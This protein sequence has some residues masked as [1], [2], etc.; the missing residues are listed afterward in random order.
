MTTYSK[1]FLNTTVKG[2]KPNHYPVFKM[3]SSNQ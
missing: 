1:N 2:T 3:D